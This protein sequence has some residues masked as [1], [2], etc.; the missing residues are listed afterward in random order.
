M[1][2]P[3]LDGKVFRVFFGLMCLP[4]MGACSSERQFQWTEDVKLSDGQMI[5][6]QRSEEYRR[7][8]DV[9]AG[10]QRGWLFQKAGIS[11]ELPAPISRKVVWEGSLS[12]LVLDI[13]PDS[14][15]YL[16]CNVITG[17]SQIEWKVPDNE[18]YVVFRLTD[19]GWQRVPLSELPLSIRPNLV[20]NGYGLF[21]KREAHSGI[22]VNLEFKSELISSFPASDQ[23]RTIIR[24]QM[25]GIKK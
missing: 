10:F 17:A 2:L 7:V 9:G 23:V 6:V 11:A 22:H 16:V 19:K 24:L 12:P 21:I 4:I 20:P 13:Q 3:W 5:V 18:F 1:R 8:M 25:P 15:V 14:A